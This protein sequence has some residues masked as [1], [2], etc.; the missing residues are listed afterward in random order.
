M[1]LMV[2]AV[3]LYDFVSVTLIRLSQGR[4]PF[5]GDRNHFSHRLVRRGLSIRAAVVVIWLCALATGLSGVMLSSLAGWQ[6]GLAAGQ[7]VAVVAV[8]ALLERGGSNGNGPV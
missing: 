7:T 5:V 2:M 6:A 8:L 1:P 3:P 4:S